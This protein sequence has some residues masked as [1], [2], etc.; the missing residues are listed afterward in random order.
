MAIDSA[1][2]RASAH[3][4]ANRWARVL[5]IPDG[6]VAQ[7]DRAHLS[8]LYGGLFDSGA[9]VLVPAARYTLGP[10]LTHRYIGRD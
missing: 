6:T 3:R 1:A 7:A 9:V 8:D 4:A 2:K 5:P 10:D